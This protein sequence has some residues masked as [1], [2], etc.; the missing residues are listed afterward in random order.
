MKEIFLE[1]GFNDFLSKPIDMPKMDAILKKWIPAEKR[2]D[3]PEDELETSANEGDFPEIAGIDVSDGIARIGG[4]Q[5]RYLDILETFRRDAQA[6]LPLLENAPDDASLRAFTTLVH[7]MKSALATIGASALS[8]S[9]ALLEDAGRKGELSAIQARITP[10]RAGIVALSAR[11]GE[12]LTKMRSSYEDARNVLGIEILIG[13]RDALDRKSID[14][15]DDT[16]AKLQALPLPGGAHEDISYVADLILT[17]D[18]KKASEAVAELIRQ[19][20]QKESAAAPSDEERRRSAG[21][22]RNGVDDRRQRTED[23]R[24]AVRDR[25][26]GSKDRRQQAE[27]RRQGPEDE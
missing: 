20:K 24:L 2:E 1:N 10:F 5:S 14:D 17:A 12:V 18:F 11:I 4:S 21:D 7:A 15:I 26:Q 25:R 19:E 3:I 16:L 8:Q 6:G 9:A 27:D 23:R 22:R 13:L